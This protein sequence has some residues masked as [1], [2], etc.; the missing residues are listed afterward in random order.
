MAAISQ[1]ISNYNLGMSNQ[2]AYKKIP[3]QVDWI[4]NATP[5]VTYGLPKRGGSKRI[6]SNPLSNVQ[7]DGTFFHYYRDESEGSYI[8]QVAANG[9][10]RMW[11]C[12]DGTEKNVWYHTDDSAYSSSNSDHTSITSYLTSSDPENI[13][14]LTINDTTFVTNRSKVVTTSNAVSSGATYK[15]NLWK[16]MPTSSINT[17]WNGVVTI[18]GH[19][20]QTGDKVFYI[21]SGSGLA[22]PLVNGTAYYVIR[23][24]VN[25]FR[26]ATTEANAEGNTWINITAVGNNAQ[27]LEYGFGIITVTKTNHGLTAGDAIN[28]TFSADNAGAKPIDGA[29]NVTSV[30]DADTFIL[31]DR[32]IFNS[33]GLIDDG[34]SLVSCTYYEST[35]APPDQYYAYLDLLRSEN[36]RQYSLNINNDDTS[37]G[38]VT[39]KVATRVKISSTTQST[40]GG[41]GHCP[42]IGTQVFAVTAASSYSGTNIVSVK[43]SAGTDITTGKRNLIFRI[44]AL[45]QQGSN[46]NGNFDDANISAN[47]YMCSYSNRVELL[48]GGEGWEEG[49]K[50]TVTLDQAVTNYNFEI[51]I[52]KHETSVVKASIR[53]VRPE[54]T[55]FD[56]DTAVSPDIILGGITTELSHGHHSGV[57]SGIHW[58]IV[59]NG[60][61]L[62]AAVP[63]NIHVPDK[64]LIRVMQSEINDVSELPNQCIHGYIVKVSNSRQSDEDDYYLR[65]VGENN[66]DG[67][68]SWVECAKPGIIKGLDAATMPHVLQRRPD[69]DFL[70]KKYSWAERDVGDDVT[71]PMPSFADGSSKINK[72]LFH[73]NRL[74]LLS[75][76]NVILSRPGELT[77]PSFFAKTALAVSAIDPIDISSSS[78]Y[79][80][81]LYD[82]IEVTTGLVVF[83]TNQQFLLSAD[84]EVLNP[85]TAKLK[86]ISHYNYDKKVPPISLG[87]T[88]AYLD[89]TGQSARFMEMANIQRE[90]EPTIIETSKVVDDLMPNDIDTLINSRENGLV[91]FYKANHINKYATSNELEYDPYIYGLKYQNS[92]ERR[93]LSSWFTW[94]VT[95]G[96]SSGRHKYLFIIDDAF[97]ILTANNFLVRNNLSRGNEILDP[98]TPA[99]NSASTTDYFKKDRYPLYLDNWT[100]ITGGVYNST[101]NKTTFTHGTNGCVFDWHNS[102]VS[103]NWSANYL[104]QMIWFDPLDHYTS[105]QPLVDKPRDIVAGTSFTVKGDWSGKTSYIGYSYEYEVMLPTFYYTQQQG[106]NIKP[107]LEDYLV[108][109]R[110]KFKLDVNSSATIWSFAG[111]D[112]MYKNLYWS[113]G[114]EGRRIGDY[115]VGDIPQRQNE[116]ITYPLYEKNTL[117]AN[118]TILQRALGDDAD[119]T[120]EYGPCNLHAVTWEGDYTPKN[121]RRV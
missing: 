14:P 61:Y 69:G 3:G 90:G 23:I 57:F 104:L 13:Q 39:I 37:A 49:D 108:I 19:G 71:N 120:H 102:L 121:Y 103:N 7:T 29:Y 95:S 80:S 60:L 82:G 89:N 86:S 100:T 47:E 28:V 2:P 81:D 18:N 116:T 92:G 105:E 106:E 50:V 63:F 109:H 46:P 21:E 68:G 75:G 88:I 52:E 4:T 1:T 26:L 20:F 40:A 10:V 5:D 114:L 70:I 117:I 83:S 24:D 111:L 96:G 67:P 31:T 113:T 36:G 99:V 27:Y 78:I 94:R 74:A 6:G 87:T 77:T 15:R 79:P 62:W 107:D 73:R 115:R 66:K 30:T 56:A 55:P 11:S 51:R 17:S 45:G 97:Y 84:A 12:N 59:G 25:T 58:H 44:T 54:P 48:H 34:N 35:T 91:F 85:D 42:G 76:E 65:F 9:R 16:A 118:L 98:H 112:P 22:T 93:L 64:D 53:A 32:S 38:D 43:N 8:G 72:V 33:L 101:T 110:V 119:M 41:T